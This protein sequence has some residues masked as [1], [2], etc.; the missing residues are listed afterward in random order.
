VVGPRG[1][2]YAQNNEFIVTRFP[3][4]TLKA[5]LA[6]P[7]LAHVEHVV[8]E[9]DALD[10]PGGE[11]DV[12][13]MV[14]FYHDTYW[15]NV[16]RARM[17]AQILDA[18]KPGGI[19]GIVDHHAEEGSG[20]RDVKTLHRGDAAMIKQEIVDA[21]FEFVGES[22]LLRRPEDDRTRSV[23]DPAMRDKSDQFIYKFRKPL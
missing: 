19:Y 10:L 21:G 15:M 17:N 1:H 3:M 4:D 7:E 5:R 6:R 22:E 11:L 20:A 14:L 12:V 23:F 18:L 2:V 16:D 13:L 8:K 9:L